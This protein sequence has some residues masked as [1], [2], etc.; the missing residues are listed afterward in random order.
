VISAPLEMVAGWLGT[1][2][3]HSTCALFSA[4]VISLL[5][6]SRALAWQ[7][8]LL[9]FS[10]WAALAS[11]TVQLLVVGSPLSFVLPDVVVPGAWSVDALLAELSE[12]D[13]TAPV[14]AT[15]PASAAG[16]RHRRS[17]LATTAMAR[18]RALPQM[19]EPS[20]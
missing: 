3:V 20:R 15:A 7:E 4:W 1:F 8:R 6:R 13:A 19:Q 17:R 11:S 16:P 5:L 14:T 10:L 2:A 9:R 18:P 12:V